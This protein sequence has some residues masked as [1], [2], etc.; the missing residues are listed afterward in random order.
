MFDAEGTVFGSVNGKDVRQFK[1]LV[2]PLNIIKKYDAQV[3]N[4]DEKIDV[5]VSETKNLSSIRDSLLPKLMFGKIRVKVD[6][7]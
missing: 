4:I 3:I 7:T 2:P 6:A 1:I 5:N